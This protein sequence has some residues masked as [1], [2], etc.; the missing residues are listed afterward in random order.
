MTGD[1]AGRGDALAL[2]ADALRCPVCSAAVAVDRAGVRCAAG[3]A[4]DR[5]KQGYAGL[6]ARPLAF[7]GDDAAMIAARREVLGSGLYAPLLDAVARAAVRALA[8]GGAGRDDAAGRGGGAG[9]AAAHVA[10]AEGPGPTVLDLGCGT[11]HYLARV[12]EA[13]ADGG[14][15]GA[16]GIGLDAAKPAVRAAARA[17]PRAAALLGDAWS[18]VPVADG[19]AALILCVFAPRNTAEYARLLAPGGAVLVAAPGPGHLAE[20]VRPLGLLH[21]DDEKERRLAETMRGFDAA[22][23]QRVRWTMRPGRAGIAAIVGMGPSARHLSAQERARRIDG[24][25]EDQPV[26]GD[27]TVRLFRRPAGRR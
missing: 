27:V 20:L 25:P 14:F 5:A 23:P 11:G 21:V 10:A 4:F 18:A 6:L 3:H 19:A 17:H 13:A 15:P 26:T 8:D 9:E 2:V 16:R 22:A 7:H 24:L 1:A 12:L